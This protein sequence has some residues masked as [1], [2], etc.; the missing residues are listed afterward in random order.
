MS[1]ILTRA[2]CKVV[3]VGCLLAVAG[4][5]I[6]PPPDQKTECTLAYTEA[7]GAAV[8]G[9]CSSSMG[10]E[11]TRECQEKLT[12]ALTLCKDVKTNTTDP[13]TNKTVEVPFDEQVVQSLTKL[14]P[15]SCD[16]HLGYLSC[17]DDCSIKN[18]TMTLGKCA[19]FFMTIGFQKFES[20]SA[21]CME[22]F[23]GFQERCAG[24]KDPL[25]K[26]FLEDAAAGQPYQQQPDASK[27]SVVTCDTGCE[28]VTERLT[29]LCCPADSV[30][31]TSDGGE[32]SYECD[33]NNVP[34]TPEPG[35]PCC[36][37][38]Q[39]AA[40]DVC[41]SQFYDLDSVDLPPWGVT[42]EACLCSGVTTGCPAVEDLR[43][44]ATAAQPKP[45][46][47]PSPDQPWHYNKDDKSITLP[48]EVLIAGAIVSAV[49]LMAVIALALS[50]KTMKTATESSVFIDTKGTTIYDIPVDAPTSFV[51]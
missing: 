9:V 20:C 41:P 11:C 22:K 44:A 40:L 23:Y 15:P 27:L 2:A 17:G 26:S 29:R 31:D 39:A 37:A 10:K 43:E 18:A 14:G 30:N 45:R 48:F 33:E 8:S 4:A 28:N 12:K 42:Y 38:V 19:S 50:K 1:S 32:N 35:S 25:V 51:A 36:R 6:P 3:A 34:V 7:F 46:P 49:L 47:S 21:E 24:C 13:E 16:Y 5:Q